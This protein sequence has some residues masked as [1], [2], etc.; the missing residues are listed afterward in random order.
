MLESFRRQQIL[1]QV[2]VLAA[3]GDL[4]AEAAF[5]RTVLPAPSLP[6]G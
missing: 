6:N 2:Y 4:S 5:R 3:N 1:E